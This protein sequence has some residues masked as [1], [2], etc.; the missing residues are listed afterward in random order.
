MK[1]YLFIISQAPHT[2]V[3][4]QEN[5]DIILIMAAFDQQVSVLFLD[6]GVFA[7]KKYQQAEKYALKET[8]SIF[9]ALEIYD[10]HHLYTE[11]ES[12]QERALKPVDLCLPVKEFY[13]KQINAL[14]QQYDV[15]FSV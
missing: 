14:M 12:L 3:K 7:L 4:L 6:D 13:R 2:G 5:L 11:V 9:K 15:V 8:L 1:K 10:V